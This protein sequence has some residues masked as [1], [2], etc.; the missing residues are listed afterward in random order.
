MWLGQER[1]T[2]RWASKD[3][4]LLG[5]IKVTMD[6]L[7]EIAGRLLTLP[8]PSLGRTTGDFG[9]YDSLLGGVITRAARGEPFSPDDVPE[10]D[11]ATLRYVASLRAKQSLT[12]DE[13]YFL[14]YYQLLERA[15]ALITSV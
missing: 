4:D 8:F 1:D 14:T 9:F 3:P 2:S 11:A 10:P 13:A 7:R 6:E 15:R 5:L 12:E